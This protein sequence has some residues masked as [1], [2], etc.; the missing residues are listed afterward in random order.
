LFDVEC[1]EKDIKCIDMSWFDL[2][3]KTYKE[4]WAKCPKKVIAQ[5]KKL[6][7]FNADKFFEITGIR[8]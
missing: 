5:I 1:E 8:V 4:A 6:K 3:D 7:N 2:V